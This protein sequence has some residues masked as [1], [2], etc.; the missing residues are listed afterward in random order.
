MRAIT[1]LK[2]PPAGMGSLGWDPTLATQHLQFGFFVVD[3]PS[4]SHTHG[5]PH[6]LVDSARG[7]QLVVQC[8]EDPLGL[9]GRG[10]LALGYRRAGSDRGCACLLPAHH[11]DKGRHAR[12]R[13][14]RM[15]T[16]A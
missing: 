8:H 13:D 5:V 1:T 15:Q 14:V 9:V 7:L 6:L 4:Q 3:A 12:G 11:A 2:S 10:L 16:K